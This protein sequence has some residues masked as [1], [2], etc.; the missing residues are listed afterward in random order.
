MTSKEFVI[1]LKGFTEGVHDFNIT[2]KQWDLMKNK[3]DQVSDES[4]TVYPFGVPNGTSPFNPAITTVPNGTDKHPWGGQV[5]WAG[6]PIDCL[7]TTTSGYI[8]PVGQEIPSSIVTS[9][10]TGT[11]TYYPAGTTVTYTVTTG[12]GT[13]FGVTHTNPHGNTV[14]Y[15]NPQ[16]GSWH[17]TNS[18]DK[19]LLHD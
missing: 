14:T 2:P 1:W 17:Y 6:T 3:L 10:S 12:S 11:A 8:A 7:R 5:V 15:V 16:S 18:T 19:T 13:G 9:G 4:K